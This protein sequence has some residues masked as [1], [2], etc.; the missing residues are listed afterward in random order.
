MTGL[1]SCS[2]TWPK[3]TIRSKRS[4]PPKYSNTTTYWSSS[5]I[6]STGTVNNLRA[7][8]S[9]FSISISRRRTASS[10][11]RTLWSAVLLIHL[12]ATHRFLFLR[13]LPSRT[14][15]NPPR[16]IRFLTSY[17]SPRR[18]CFR[19]CEL[20]SRRRSAAGSPEPRAPREVN[21]APEPSDSRPSGR[22]L[23]DEF[24][25]FAAD[26]FNG[27]GDE[28]EKRRSIRDT[29]GSSLSASSAWTTLL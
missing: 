13:S 17:R 8:S 19:S 2:E 4:P 5:S 15:P 16:P 6:S 23:L 3:C 10:V 18:R 29:H 21:L 22:G 7:S 1:R 28:D 20:R 12:S 9:V 27:W 25:A 24:V 26:S 14:R 11:W